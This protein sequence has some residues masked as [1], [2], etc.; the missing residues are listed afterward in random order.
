M[1][2]THQ[3][4]EDFLG[5]LMQYIEDHL[6]ERDDEANGETYP[7]ETVDVLNDLRAARTAWRAAGS[8]EPYPAWYLATYGERDDDDAPDWLPPIDA[9]PITRW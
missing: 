7:A 1:E 8:P 4:L 5:G 9:P 2:T 3:S 6:E